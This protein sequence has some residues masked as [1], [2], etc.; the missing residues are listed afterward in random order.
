MRAQRGFSIFELLLAVALSTVL[1]F[2]AAGILTQ[3]ARAADGGY[4]SARG[5]GDIDREL[6]A[7]R[8]D[9]ATAFAVFVP[10]RGPASELDFY[11]KTDGGR[12][13]FWRYAFD[14]A[15][16]ALRRSDYDV[17]GESGVRDPQTGT[18]DPRASYPPLPNVVAFSAQVLPATQLGSKINPYGTVSGAL[19]GPGARALPVSF[20]NGG[21]PRRELY[22][23]NAIVQVRLANATSARTLH[24]LSGALPS[25]FTFHAAPVV[26]GVVYR[27]DQTHRFWFGLAQVSHTWIDGRVDVSYDRW[28]T[29]ATWCDF[30]IYGGAHGIDPHSAQ[31]N[32]NPEDYN[33]S[34]AGLLAQAQADP[35]CGAGPPAPSSPGNG[36]TFTPP[37]ALADTPPPCFSAP[38]PGTPRCWPPQAPADWAPSPLP[39]ERPPDAWCAGHRPSAACREPQGR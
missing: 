23:G 14:P 37:P 28:R 34:F 1:G 24:L 15:A 3:I 12:D 17:T 38:A 39:P 13:V 26:H 2:A 29:S 22:G 32:Y 11:S 6:E 7:L 33:E 27:I 21:V 35:G 25:G 9:A 10:A 18:I 19:I 20:D 16:H 4:A 31:A 5:S 36:R 30:N 8:S